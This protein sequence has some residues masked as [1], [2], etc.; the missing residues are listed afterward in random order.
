MDIFE[1]TPFPDPDRGRNAPKNK[2]HKQFYGYRISFLVSKSFFGHRDSVLCCKLRSSSSWDQAVRVFW[3]SPS[4][5]FEIKKI[6]IPKSRSKNLDTTK[7]RHL[8]TNQKH[9]YLNSVQQMVCGE[10]AGECLQT[11]F[12]SRGLPAQRAPL[13][14]VYPLRDHL[15]SVQ[16]L[17]SGGCCEG[18]FPDRVCWTRLRNAWR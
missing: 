10:L 1:K 18:L 14:T 15:N 3:A 5:T 16:R 12:E 4:C 7:K 11:G 13:D 2:T 17:V 9:V 8:D 6:S